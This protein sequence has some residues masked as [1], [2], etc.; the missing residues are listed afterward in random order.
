MLYYVLDSS[1]PSVVNPKIPANAAADI[2]E[3]S[4]PD[5]GPEN[6]ASKVTCRVCQEMIDVI[7][8]KDQHVVKCN[9]C[10]EAT[11][12]LLLLKKYLI[13][14]KNIMYLLKYYQCI[15]F[16]LHYI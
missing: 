11:V 6:T 2:S 14:V 5:M 3:F 12:S 9:R 8:K 4:G 16:K 15:Q 13:V 7:G 1:P 10:N